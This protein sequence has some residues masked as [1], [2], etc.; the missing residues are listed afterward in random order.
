MA[1]MRAASAAHWLRMWQ[2][3][4]ISQKAARASGLT[5]NSRREAMPNPQFQPGRSMAGRPWLPLFWEDCFLERLENERTF[6]ATP[7]KG[8]CRPETAG[9]H[10]LI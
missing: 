6:P 3:A 9:F 10:A 4:M 7:C 5:A 1:A 2:I 8:R